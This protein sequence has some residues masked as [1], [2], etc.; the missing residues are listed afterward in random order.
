MK[1]PNKSAWGTIE[2]DNLDAEWAFKNFAGKSLD[3]AENMFRKNALYYQ[4]DLIS[5]PSIAF[6]CYAPVFAKYILSSHAE[7]DSDGASSFLHM[8]IELLDANI[9]LAS[10][11]TVK[12][13][14]EAAK[15]VSSKQQY[16]DA[17]ID[18]YGEFPE[19][20]DKIMLLVEQDTSSQP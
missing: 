13:L 11:E 7:S 17:D 8:I 9:S 2:E 10:S 18:I 15:I 6:N 19:L 20:Y 4:E 5:M 16:Y 12:I 3:D 14:L 1:I